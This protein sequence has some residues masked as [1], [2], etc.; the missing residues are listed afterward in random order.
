MIRD[1][2]ESV[3]VVWTTL[4]ANS[5]PGSFARALVKEGLAACVTTQEGLTSVYR[6]QDSIED[7]VEYQLTIKTTVARVEALERRVAELHPYDV[8]EFL[9][10]PVL[11]GSA[12]YLDWV[13]SSTRR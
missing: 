12:A 10:S 1:E 11:D 5:A 3:V 6:W 9:V 7:A 4:P 8:P 13:R 2:G